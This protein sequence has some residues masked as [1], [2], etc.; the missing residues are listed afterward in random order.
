M[1]PPA[2]DA[3]RKPASEA[4]GILRVTADPASGL[5]DDNLLA[6]LA[7][8]RTVER[9]A[10]QRVWKELDL[11]P[12]PAENSMEVTADTWANYT[13]GQGRE[14]T[15]K[16]PGVGMVYVLVKSYDERVPAAKLLAAF[17]SAL[18]NRLREL[19]GRESRAAALQEARE[20]LMVLRD[21]LSKERQSL[22]AL[23]AIHKVDI[24]PAPAAQRR[25]R[26]ESELQSLG[27]QLEG[28]KARR[29]IIEAQIAEL[30]NV[31]T[32]PADSEIL[33]QLVRSIEARRKIVEYQ[34]AANEAGNVRGSIESLQKAK[35]ELAQAELELAR[36]RRGAIDAAAGGRIAQLRER[37]DDTAIEI[38]ETEVRRK[39]LDEQYKQ[40]KSFS[41]QVA[42]MRL[43]VELL[44][45]Q[46]RTA[47]GE[48]S[49][50]E[51][52]LAQR[53]EPRLTVIPLRSVE[54]TPD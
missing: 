7:T 45:N 11:S 29:Q 51:S 4:A 31:K 21:T 36:Y 18:H 15:P 22:V 16:T 54:A 44:E 10:Q 30:G 35:D 1:A 23:A 20:R 19:D 8:S 50:L 42:E 53:I 25:L 27:V 33:T 28:L 46:Y 40:S 39:T 12:L 52:A 32:S 48:L 17:E 34:T 3:P 6:N 13:I 5:A 49:A 2:D 41:S 9:A 43:E 14:M 24:D 26:L 47:A 38:A 37:L